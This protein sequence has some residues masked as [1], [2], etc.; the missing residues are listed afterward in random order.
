MLDTGTRLSEI[1]GL[2][3]ED[4]DLASCSLVVRGKGGQHW[5]KTPFTSPTRDAIEVLDLRQQQWPSYLGAMWPGP[6][7]AVTVRASPRCSNG[8]AVR[9]ESTSCIHISSATQPP[10]AGWS[11]VV[12]KAM[13]C[14]FWAGE[15]GSCSIVTVQLWPPPELRRPT[16][17]SCRR[18]ASEGRP[19][20]L[21]VSISS[22]KR[23]RAKHPLAR[24]SANSVQLFA[25]AQPHSR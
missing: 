4:V 14:V 6:K 16:T 20:P 17:E 15:A 10:T 5:R 25:Y 3:V 21:R 9:P 2:S 18:S 13:P 1:A 8:A 11:E 22:A 23:R 19:S 12:A 24:P 7:G